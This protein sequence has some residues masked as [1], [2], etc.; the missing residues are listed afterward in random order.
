M[1]PF[2]RSETLLSELLSRQKCDAQ[3]STER[4][5]SG[6]VKHALRT[7]GVCSD[8]SGWQEALGGEWSDDAE[9]TA[10]EGSHARSSA[11][12]WRREDL[13]SPAVEH[14]VEHG[15]EEAEG[16]IVSW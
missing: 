8:A 16:R 9:Q 11:S 6:Q 2:A 4:D 7:L 14:C 12:H 15:L 5:A 13:G 1:Q 10:P 3:N